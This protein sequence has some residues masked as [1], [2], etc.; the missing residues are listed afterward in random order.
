MDAVLE[1]EEHSI[2]FTSQMRKLNEWQSR[3][4]NSCLFH[5]SE[6]CASNLMIR[7]QHF[8]ITRVNY[9][10]LVKLPLSLEHIFL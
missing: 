6:D 7:N 9:F 5:F 3:A 2:L 4:T 10:N 8:P 1:W